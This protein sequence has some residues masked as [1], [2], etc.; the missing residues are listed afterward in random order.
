MVVHNP[1][2]WHWID[3]NCLPWSKEY[4]STHIKDTSYEN[5]DY[6]FVITG[7]NSVT[8]D[9]DVTQRKGKVLCIYDMRLSFALSILNKQLKEDE[10]ENED[11]DGDE[12]EA[13]MAYGTITIPEFVH[14]QEE[15]EYV[16]EIDSEHKAEI[17]KLL[18]P[19]LKS[20]LSKFQ[21]DLIEAHAKDVQHTSGH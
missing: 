20:K 13:K 8:G 15:D 7:V 19:K 6:R 18:V 17:V 11:E 5:D 16:F 3:K 14:D 10:N 1:N 2:N 4:F 21:N 9:C 12:K